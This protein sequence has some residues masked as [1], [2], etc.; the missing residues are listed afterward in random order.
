MS[1]CFLEA[2]RLKWERQR[3]ALLSL[4]FSIADHPLVVHLTMLFKMFLL[5]IRQIVPCLDELMD[6]AWPSGSQH[7]EIFPSTSKS[8]HSRDDS[9]FYQMIN[10]RPITL[11]F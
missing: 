4:V 3:K 5:A 2:K 9:I 6:I 7:D 10:K 8:L 1:L 11:Y